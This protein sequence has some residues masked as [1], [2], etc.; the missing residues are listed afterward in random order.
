MNSL[1]DLIARNARAAGKEPLA[2]TVYVSVD[3][4]AV[5]ASQHKSDPRPVHEVVADE[6]ES[7]LESLDYVDQAVV[8]KRLGR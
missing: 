2:F 6:I 4:E 7:N 5:R 3:P 1:G 8:R